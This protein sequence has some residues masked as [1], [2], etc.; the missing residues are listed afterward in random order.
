ML[1]FTASPDRGRTWPSNPFGIATAR[2]V[3]TSTIAPGSIRTSASTA[4]WRSMPAAP[5]VMY[6]G[7]ASP[8]ACGRRWI[9]SVSARVTGQ[10]LHGVG[11]RHYLHGGIAH[12][13]QEAIDRR[14]APEDL[15]ARARALAEDHVR[16]PFALRERDQALGRTLRLHA[17][18]GRA[19]ALGE[20]DVLLQRVGVVQVDA[21]RTL[22]RRLDVDRVPPRAE[23]AG[24]PR[25]GADDAR[26]E[27]VRAHA[28]HHTLGNERRLEAFAR[29][30]ARG[31]LAH[32]V[33]DSAQRQLA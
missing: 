15:P 32:F 19:E 23:A 26:R 6:V 29:A 5:S 10:M 11:E 12:G 24:D 9:G 2:P 27:R 22:L 7:S 17:D 16:D 3:G 13:A 20:L 8:S 14:A 21:I 28:H 18:D 31:L 1:C 30:V 33:C 4:A 25:A